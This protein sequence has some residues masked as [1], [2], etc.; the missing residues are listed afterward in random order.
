MFK[1]GLRLGSTM[2][3]FLLLSPFLA[4][5]ILL[6]IGKMSASCQPPVPLG[7][8]I[9]AKRLYPLIFN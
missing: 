8:K 6:E 5:V 1:K 9:A 3:P 7:Y 4:S 2:D